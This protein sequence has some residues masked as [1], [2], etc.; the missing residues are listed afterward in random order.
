MVPTAGEL[1]ALARVDPAA[2]ANR[3][4]QIVDGIG[5]D[6]TAPHAE[7]LEGL[8][9]LA[10]KG[11]GLASAATEPRGPFSDPT[12]PGAPRRMAGGGQFASDGQGL[13]VFGGGYGKP[14]ERVADLTAWANGA[15]SD[16][17]MP[18]GDDPEPRDPR[19]EQG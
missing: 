14:P 5:R 18:E 9:A 10:L 17:T 13:R 8:K 6:T 3:L 12:A 19:Y 11:L 1:M 16:G 2:A 7:E 4:N 15:I